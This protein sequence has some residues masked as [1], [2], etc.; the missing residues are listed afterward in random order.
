[1]VSEEAVKNSVGMRL[2]GI[3]PEDFILSHCKNFLHGLRSAL[4]IRTKDIDILSIQP[5]EAAMSKEKRDTN[6]DLDVLFAV[7]KSPHVYFPSKQLL[8]KIKTTSNLK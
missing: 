1:M 3:T 5:S 2:K 4:N 6:R 8:A 7:R